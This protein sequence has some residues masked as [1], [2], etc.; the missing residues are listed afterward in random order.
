[1]ASD[2]RG[3]PAAEGFDLETPFFEDDGTL[4]HILYSRKSFSLRELSEGVLRG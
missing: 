1:M 3:I 2:S 4:S